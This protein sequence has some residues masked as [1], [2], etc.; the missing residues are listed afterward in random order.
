MRRDR[1][2]PT[3]R[4]RGVLPA[5][6]QGRN[7]AAACAETQAATDGIRCRDEAKRPWRTPVRS[8]ASISRREYRS[9]R[10]RS[11]SASL[12]RHF[13]RCCTDEPASAHRWRCASRERLGPAR[14][15]GSTCRRATTSGE[16]ADGHRECSERWRRTGRSEGCRRR[17]RSVA[18]STRTV[19]S[20]QDDA[21]DSVLP[22]AVS[23]RDQQFTGSRRTSQRERGFKGQAVR[24]P[25]WSSSWPVSGGRRRGWSPGARRT[26]ALG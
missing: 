7:P 2:L 6:Q 24:R 3:Q 22:V 10:S 15:C 26:D 5:R 19:Q 21:R 20:E 12:G 23:S 14:R 9:V 18:E 8:F 13:P 4:P 1:E 16:R 25:D 17:I 11:A